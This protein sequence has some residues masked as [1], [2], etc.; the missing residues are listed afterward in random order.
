MDTMLARM[1]RSVKKPMNAAGALKL[2]AVIPASPG[3][4]CHFTEVVS[5]IASA[6]KLFK[7]GS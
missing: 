4:C 1:G 6:D 3:P 2:S 5:T 7:G